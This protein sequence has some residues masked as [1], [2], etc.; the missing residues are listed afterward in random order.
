MRRRH[1]L[2]L[3]RASRRRRNITRRATLL[4]VERGRSGRPRFII[5]LGGACLVAAAAH[6]AARHGGP[7]DVA[8]L[9]VQLTVSTSSSRP[10][11]A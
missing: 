1:F 11:T 6:V 5:L 3:V 9:N 4:Y 7:F 8:E 2:R 10:G